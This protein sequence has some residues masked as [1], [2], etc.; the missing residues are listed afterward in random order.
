[1]YARDEA[2]IATPVG[3]V[4]LVADGDELIAVTIG[5]DLAAVRAKSDMLQGAARQVEQWFAG[6][7][8]TFD[9]AL[10]PAATPRGTAL[11]DAIVSIGYGQTMTYGALAK[12]VTSSARAV[13]Q[14]CARNPFPLIVPCHRVLAAGGILGAYSAG[15]GASTKQWLLDHER[16][17]L[18]QEQCHE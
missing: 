14:A 15:D 3:A 5:R 10:N 4:R 9:I 13:G 2:V 16:R 12:A 6:E 18:R 1:M 17:N 8:V 11:R 7:R